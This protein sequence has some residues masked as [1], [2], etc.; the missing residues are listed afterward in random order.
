MTDRD[1]LM[2][3]ILDHPDED[4]PRL[5]FADWLQENGQPDRATFVRRQC[6]IARLVADEPAGQNSM[7]L[8]GYRLAMH[9]EQSTMAAVLD[10]PPCRCVLC[11]QDIVRELFVANGPNQLEWMG[12]AVHDVCVLGTEWL[13]HLPWFRRGFVES[14]DCPADVWLQHGA[15]I[16]RE[17]PVRRVWHPD[18]PLLVGTP[19]LSNEADVVGL[20]GDPT[21]A[22]FAWADVQ[23]EAALAGLS[24][25]EIGGA[26]RVVCRLRW[27]G[28][29]VEL[30]PHAFAELGRVLDEL[31]RLPLSARVARDERGERI[32]EALRDV[33]TALGIRPD[34]P[35]LEA[36]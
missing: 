9:R 32:C 18:V 6:E 36:R 7:W 14:V 28:L 13:D 33:R 23:A 20:S 17:Q 22:M 11:L 21:G 34:A 8:I 15:A 24:L 29:A 19:L 16:R 10:G 2:R 5:M 30:R 12:K 35:D 1:A 3:A 25:D 4:T 26:T 27:P 31:H